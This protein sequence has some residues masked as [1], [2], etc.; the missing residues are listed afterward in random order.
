MTPYILH[1]ALLLT[2]CLLFYKL[3]LQRETFF[4]LNRFVLLACFLLS[5]SLPMLPVPGQW[6]LRKQEPAAVLL[7]AESLLQTGIVPDE[8]AA[9]PAAEVK[10]TTPTNSFSLPKMLQWAAWLYWFGVAAF[11]LNLL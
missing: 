7:P 6:S 9:G 5:F 8:K 3:L 10:A 11:A 4:R 2:A 1:V